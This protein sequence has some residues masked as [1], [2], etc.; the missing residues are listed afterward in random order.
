M[1]EKK[2]NITGNIPAG[3]VKC[4]VDSYLSIL[5]EILN[6]ALEKGN[7]PNQLKLA[8]SLPLTDS[9]KK[10]DELYKEK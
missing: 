6:T 1:D 2:A 5:S 7:F 4:C 10:E 9:V 8:E 3:I